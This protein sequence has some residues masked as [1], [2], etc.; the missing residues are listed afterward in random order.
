MTVDKCP[1]GALEDQPHQHA[2]GEHAADAQSAIA[3]TI[4]ERDKR[5]SIKPVAD[6]G[7]DPGAK[8]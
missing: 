4:G 2:D 3:E 6:L 7:D 8:E 1:R 5:D